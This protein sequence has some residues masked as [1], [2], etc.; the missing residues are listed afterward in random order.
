MGLLGEALMHDSEGEGLQYCGISLLHLAWG[1]Q[2]L[3]W[4]HLN[5]ES[6]LG[7]LAASAPHGPTEG[8]LVHED[9]QPPE[10]L[11][12]W[13]V[14]LA[15]A[16]S[17]LRPTLAMC[18]LSFCHSSIMQSSCCQWGTSLGGQ[19][20]LPQYTCFTR[21]SISLSVDSRRVLT[22]GCAEA[23]TLAILIG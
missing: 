18:W 16:S 1:C 22:E 8:D 7:H 17:S 13:E 3:E 6:S 20:I 15:G 9:E 4:D 2:P 14:G 23:I 12:L 21:S 5:D 10:H 11:Q 19:H